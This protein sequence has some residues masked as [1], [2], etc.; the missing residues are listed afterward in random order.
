VLGSV[1]LV[2]VLGATALG[3]AVG[4]RLRARS[5]GFREPFAAVQTALLGLVGLIWAF[6]PG[7]RGRTLRVS[8]CGGGAGR[9]RDR[10]DVPTSADPVGT[11]AH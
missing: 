6:G 5:E 4:K 9:Q 8:A 1:L 2:V 3:L 10:D 11:R 7:P